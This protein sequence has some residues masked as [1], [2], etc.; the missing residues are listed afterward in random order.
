MKRPAT[1]TRGSLKSSGSPNRWVV[2]VDIEQVESV[3]HQPE[4]PEGQLE[5]LLEPQIEE[6]QGAELAR[7]ACLAVTDDRAATSNSSAGMM[8]PSPFES[9]RV[10]RAVSVTDRAVGFAAAP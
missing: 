10:K 4:P 7:A 5:L 8:T 2:P 1:R 3:A 9:Q 6:V